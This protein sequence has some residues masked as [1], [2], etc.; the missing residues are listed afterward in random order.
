MPV[1]IASTDI[2]NPA[3]KF[4]QAARIQRGSE[5][6]RASASMPRPARNK[7]GGKFE[8]E[9]Y[10]YSGGLHGV[11]VS[12]VNFLSEWLEVEVKRDGKIYHQR[13]ERGVPKTKL[14]SIGSAK[15]TGT[16]M[17]FRPDGKIFEDI[18]KKAELN[19][20]TSSPFSEITDEDI[21]NLFSD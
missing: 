4:R 20:S 19:A 3:L 15:K 18:K 1:S 13:F 11:G 12:C 6:K 10:Q 14:K 9:A 21:D 16:K 8:K 7:A 5:R 2:S 17:R